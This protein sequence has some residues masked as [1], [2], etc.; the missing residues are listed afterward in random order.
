MTDTIP[1]AEDEARKDRD[2]RVSTPPQC[3]ARRKPTIVERIRHLLLGRVRGF[4]IDEECRC[5]GYDGHG[6]FDY[7]HEDITGFKWRHEALDA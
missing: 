5:C 3:K 2:Y 6:A 4:D 1:Q 7:P